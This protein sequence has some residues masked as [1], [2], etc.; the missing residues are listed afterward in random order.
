LQLAEL[1]AA[2]EPCPRFGP[3]GELPVIFAGNRDARA[4]V[5]ETLQDLVALQCVP[6]LRPTLTQ[7]NLEPAR[8]C[9]HSLFMTHV[10]SRA[11]GYAQL[12]GMCTAAIRPTPAACGEAIMLLANRSAGT[13]LAVDVGGATT[14]VFSVQ[15]GRLHRTVSANLGV[16]YSLAQVLHEVGLASILRWLTNPPP[17]SELHN[18]IL[19]KMVRPTTIP[20]L[21]E[22]LQWEQAVATEAMAL[23]FRQHRQMAA[24]LDGSRQGQDVGD[25]FRQEGDRKSGYDITGVDLIVG[26]GGVLTHA[27][28]AEQAAL[29]LVNALAPEGVT[30]LA[31]DQAGIL[32]QIGML[33]TLD[34]AA[35]DEVLH[36]DVLVSLGTCVSP[37]THSSRRQGRLARYRLQAAGEVYAGDLSLGEIKWHPLPVDTQA[38]LTLEPARGVDWGAGPG[39]ALHCQVQGGLCGVILD[40]RDRPHQVTDLTGPEDW[41]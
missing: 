23:A 38:E 40:G 14:D 32:P 16:S 4:A 7:E 1:L 17:R 20:H 3:V 12:T 39:Q 29:M 35:A 5:A 36:T 2:S 11:P 6:N 25:A 28:V 10:M 33:A 24:R 22:D 8:E 37:L 34:P 15:E 13:I 18:R 31:L 30:R 9:I 41:S 26:R 21:A 27:P 19:N